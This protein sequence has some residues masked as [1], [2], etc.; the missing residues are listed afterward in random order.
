MAYLDLIQQLLDVN[1]S[2]GLK[3]G[4]QNVQRLQQILQFPDRS[5]VSIHVAGTNGKGSVCI[6]VARALEAAGYRV[7]LYTSP[8]ISSFRERIR[9]NRKLI[10]EEA[11]ESLLPPLFKVIKEAGIPA[12]FFEIATFLAFLYFAQEKVDF[13]VLETGLGGKLDATNIVNP[14]LSII[15]SISL[16]HTEFLGDSCEKIAYEKGGII[17]EGVPVIIG[18]RVPLVPIKAIAD[19]KRSAC[20]QITCTHPLYEMENNSIAKTALDYLAS[21]FP[22]PHAAIEQGLEARQPCRLE[23][24][25]GSPLII[26]DVAHNPD[27][28]FHLFKSIRRRFPGKDLR[29]LF[30]LSKSKDLSGCLNGMIPHGSHFHIVEASNGRSASKEDLSVQLQKFSVNPSAISLHDSIAASVQFARDEA[31]KQGQIL[32]IFGTFFIMGEVRQ[33]LDFNEP[34]DPFDMNERNSGKKL[35]G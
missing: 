35:S 24:L 28:I 25:A 15:T 29:L 18:P 3:L 2:A 11:V 30:A 12:T 7:G 19:Q 27:G 16:D 14:C 22:L 33:A 31:L 8:H 17:K 6:K 26:L 4:L 21:L 20:L 13:A 34:F 5:F 32:V 10:P 1:I 9:I 23:I